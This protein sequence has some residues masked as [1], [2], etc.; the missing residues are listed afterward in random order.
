MDPHPYG[1]AHPSASVTITGQCNLHESLTGTPIVYSTDSPFCD[2]LIETRTYGWGDIHP[3]GFSVAANAA[4]E[5][6]PYLVTGQAE[7]WLSMM[8]DAIVL[9]GTG[10]GLLHGFTTFSS[11]AGGPLGRSGIALDSTFGNYA[12][13]IGAFTYPFVFGETIAYSVSTHL[14]MSTPFAPASSA[15]YGFVW[16][17]EIQR[18]TD[19]EGNDVPG[20]LIVEAGGGTGGGENGSAA[21]PEPSAGLLCAFALLTAAV[22]KMRRSA[23]EKAPGTEL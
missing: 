4:F 3:Y 5:G 7:V 13:M 8:L 22:L 9:G 17:A 12:G 14:L 21:V 16:N 23:R 6:G 20:A 19:A 2:D 11:G 15:G 18:I 10:Q 1:P